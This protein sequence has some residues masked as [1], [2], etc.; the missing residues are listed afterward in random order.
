MIPVAWLRRGRDNI[1]M[2]LDLL[3]LLLFILL[4][5]MIRLRVYE[6]HLVACSML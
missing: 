3:Q 2:A 1:V 5:Q 4:R 6:V